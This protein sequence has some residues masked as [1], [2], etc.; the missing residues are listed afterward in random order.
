M[1]RHALV[2]VTA[3]GVLTLLLIAHSYR[4]YINP[5]ASPLELRHHAPADDVAASLKKRLKQK[6]SL[7]PGPEPGPPMPITLTSDE[8]TL[9]LTKLLPLEAIRFDAEIVEGAA[10][11]TLAI[12]AAEFARLPPPT[13]ALVRTLQP[14]LA[15]LNVRATAKLKALQG[16]L[17]LSVLEVREPDW[18]DRAYVQ[19]ILTALVARL[20]AGPPRVLQDEYSFAVEDIELDGDVAIVG[21][22]RLPAGADDGKKH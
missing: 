1:M 14:A 11:L 19:A 8:L 3:T 15:W 21:A 13:Q 12:P 9:M 18:L 16:K 4:R 2:L 22:R 5:S 17:Q 6:T 10:V 20:P 7:P